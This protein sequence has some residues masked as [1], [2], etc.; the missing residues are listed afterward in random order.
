MIIKNELPILLIKKKT[1][2]LK[3]IE[4]TCYLTVNHKSQQ[5]E[6]WFTNGMF[7]ILINI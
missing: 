6:H 1:V 7:H 4:Q 3:L 2:F 5:I